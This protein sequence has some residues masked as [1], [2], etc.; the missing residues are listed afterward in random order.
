MS[1]SGDVYFV[2]IP[3]KL[4]V[5]QAVQPGQR[6][7]TF[8]VAQGFIHL[9]QMKQ[10]FRQLLK[11]KIF[12]KL[13]IQLNHALRDVSTITAYT[14][15]G[16]IFARHFPA[17]QLQCFINTRKLSLLCFLDLFFLVLSPNSKSLTV[18]PQAL[19][20]WGHFLSISLNVCDTQ[21]RLS[22]WVYYKFTSSVVIWTS[23]LQQ[24][25]SRFIGISWK[26]KI[27]TSILERKIKTILHLLSAFPLSSSVNTEFTGHATP[28]GL[29]KG[30]VF[31]VSFWKRKGGHLADKL[32][33][34]IERHHSI[35]ACPSEDSWWS[36]KY[37]NPCRGL[38]LS[39]MASFSDGKKSQSF[40]V[41]R[42]RC[43]LVIFTESS[44]IIFRLHC[45]FLWPIA[46]TALWLIWLWR[47]GPVGTFFLTLA[48]WGIWVWQDEGLLFSSPHFLLQGL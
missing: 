25:E 37:F 22:D 15:S 45:V 23:T 21:D 3:G 34:K 38:F 19:P 39:L 20:F 33:L 31:C 28:S 35:L 30:S 10:H 32:H 14:N 4:R 48:C 16:H 43:F 24:I 17:W 13:C 2:A 7:L 36:Q 26:K 1:Y 47:R 29:S 8:I 40:C 46:I 11:L 12:F 44:W 9:K 5:S 18:N 41:E 6:V 27:T 42:S